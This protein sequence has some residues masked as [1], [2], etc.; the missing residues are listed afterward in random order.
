MYIQ[1]QYAPWTHPCQDSAYLTTSPCTYTPSNVKATA[2]TPVLDSWKEPLLQEGV[3]CFALLR[4]SRFGAASS[5]L[6]HDRASDEEFSASKLDHESGRAKKTGERRDLNP[7]PPGPQPGA[8]TTELRPPCRTASVYRDATGGM[9][10]RHA[11]IL[12]NSVELGNSC[13]LRLSRCRFRWKNFGSLFGL[14]WRFWWC[15]RRRCWTGWLRR[16]E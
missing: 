10:D 1:Y 9:N 11:A 12:A 8:L 16:R 3:P 6:D 4:A 2:H 15:R 5:S 7:R 13:S 14:G